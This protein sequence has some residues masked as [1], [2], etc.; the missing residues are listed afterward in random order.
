MLSSE[1]N[2]PVQL[3][4]QAILALDLLLELPRRLDVF[5]I[6]LAKGQD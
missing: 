2:V 6:D 1:S 5:L 3:S 4:E